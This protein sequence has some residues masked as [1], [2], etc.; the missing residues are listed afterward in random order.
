MRV[1]IQTLENGEQIIYAEE[2]GVSLVRAAQSP[3]FGET[4]E[5]PA[6]CI[7]RAAM[8]QIIR[9]CSHR[10]PADAIPMP[11]QQSPVPRARPAFRVIN[12]GN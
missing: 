9:E 2:T 12:G 10:T 8:D 11:G 6:I 7:S 5:L 3:V 4:T 1:L